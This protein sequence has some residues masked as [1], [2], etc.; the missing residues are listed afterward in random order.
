[1]IGYI[2]GQPWDV[3]AAEA[4]E[5]NTSPYLTGQDARKTHYVSSYHPIQG[6]TKYDIIIYLVIF[7]V[8]YS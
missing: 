7:N 2:K 3:T 8:E 1:M 4:A 5:V 6:T